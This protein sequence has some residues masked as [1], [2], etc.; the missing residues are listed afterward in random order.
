MRIL[1]V[2]TFFSNNIFLWITSEIMLIRKMGDFFFVKKMV[3]API[4]FFFI[5]M[6]IFRKWG[7]FNLRPFSPHFFF[8]LKNKNLYFFAL[9]RHFSIFFLIF[10][11]P[12]FKNGRFFYPP[13]FAP[14]F[15][16]FEIPHFFGFWKNGRFFCPPT[17]SPLFFLL[18]IFLISLGLSLYFFIERGKRGVLN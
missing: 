11:S 4:V 5:L 9:T 8:F 6:P 7:I 16:F 2:W 13:H 17:F 18:P 14:I 1:F 15:F 10:A 12:F 3:G